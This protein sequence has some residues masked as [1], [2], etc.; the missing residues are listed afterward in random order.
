MQAIDNLEGL[1]PLLAGITKRDTFCKVILDNV[2]PKLKT[3]LARAARDFYGHAWSNKS[4]ANGLS[5]CT[6]NG[7]AKAANRLTTVVWQASPGNKTRKLANDAAWREKNSEYV[8]AY[9]VD[10]FRHRRAND[11]AFRI[12]QNLR[13]RLWEAVKAGS[14]GKA[15]STMELTG[16][17]LP[18]LTQHLESQFTDGMNWENYGEW[19]IDH[20]KPCA[21]FDLTDPEQQ[22]ACFHFT[23]LQPLWAAD[24]LSKGDR[25]DWAAE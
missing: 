25:L 17:T 23:N 24:N 14:T 10:Y 15:A 22:R 1:L 20:I 11:P 9:L 13:K 2:P 19:H 21:S 5:P 4:L 7:T 6:H 12:A 8:A 16:C 18:E 3:P